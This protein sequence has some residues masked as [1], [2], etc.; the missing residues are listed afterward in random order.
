MIKA[1][2]LLK[3]FGGHKAVDGVDLAIPKGSCFGLLGPNGA[4]KTTTI[5]ML[6]GILK[7]DGGA[8][9]MD[10]G[11]VS[12][13]RVGFVPQE[14]ALY[15]DLSATE[16]LRFFGMLYDLTGAKLAE[17]VDAALGVANLRDRA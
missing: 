1:T 4:G 6:V 8:V 16:N 5:S 17:R 3:R 12:K 10:D 2:G 13:R 15:D 14:I 11:P 7:P 9:T